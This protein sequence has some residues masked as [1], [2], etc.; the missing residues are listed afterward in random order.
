MPRGSWGGRRGRGG[1]RQGRGGRRSQ[2]SRAHA[3]LK[4]MMFLES[5]GSMLQSSHEKDLQVNRCV[6]GLHK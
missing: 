3:D 4:E 6:T 5:Y 1:R 2:N